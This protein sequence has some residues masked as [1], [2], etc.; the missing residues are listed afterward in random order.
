MITA[1][2]DVLRDEGEAYAAALQRAGVPLDLRRVEGTV[3]GFWRWQ[4]TADRARRR[5]RGR[6][7]GPW[8]ARLTRRYGVL[9]SVR[10]HGRGLPEELLIERGEGV[11]VFDSDGKRYFD[12][13]ASLWYANIGQGV[14]RWPRRSR[15][16]CAR[17]RPTHVL[18]LSNR[19]ANELCAR[20]AALAPME[21]SKIFLTSG[22]GDSIEIAAKLARRHFINLGQ[23]ERMHLI[24]RTQGYHGTHGF[25]RRSAGSSPT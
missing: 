18:G 2:H 4:T 22:G 6:R 23:P 1:S 17:S 21:D 9:A 14:R 7:R 13:T 8:R 5:P 24:S 19:P 16:S 3:H 25:G 11:F 12:A 10:G 20:L 15:G